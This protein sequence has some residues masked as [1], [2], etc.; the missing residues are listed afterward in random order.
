[1]SCRGKARANGDL[2]GRQSCRERTKLRPM[3]RI[4][5]NERLSSG[6][7]H[8]ACLP[9][10]GPSSPSK[11]MSNHTPF[12]S[13]PTGIYTSGYVVEA[14]HAKLWEEV[15]TSTQ[16]RNSAR[17]SL[18]SRGCGPSELSGFSCGIPTGRLRL[19]GPSDPR[20]QPDTSGRPVARPF[21]CSMVRRF[22]FA[23]ASIWADVTRPGFLFRPI[24]EAHN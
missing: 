11:Q 4:V 8:G 17:N 20:M 3:R 9:L 10:I 12:S 18:R 23:S 21:N 7:L 16:W 13:F 1:M 24:Q 2:T 15:V 6:R 22:V 5:G 14:K 19:V